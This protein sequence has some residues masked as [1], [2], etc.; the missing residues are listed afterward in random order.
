MAVNSVAVASLFIIN[1]FIILF[2]AG[3]CSPLIRL[4][5]VPLKYRDANC[6]SQAD[7]NELLRGR[8]SSG[9]LSIHPIVGVVLPNYPLTCAL[10]ET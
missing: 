9:W 1:R 7:A 8:R 3:E 5:G 4:D 10:R 6:K 2:S